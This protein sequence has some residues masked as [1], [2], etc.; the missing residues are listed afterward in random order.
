MKNLVKATAAV[1]AILLLA[2]CGKLDFSN[3]NSSTG[4]SK[5]GQYQT[6]GVASDGTYQGVIKN[7]RYQVSKSRGLMMQNNNQ[8]GN[9]FNV[10]SM[11][12]GLV[13]LSQKQF[14]T[15]KYDFEEG[16]LLS[17]SVTRKWL[18][19]QK[20]KF[21]K[22]GDTDNALGLNP[23][24]N[25]STDPN[26]RVPIYLQQL[27]EQD[28][29]VKS[30]NSMALGGISI[31]LGMNAID[32]YVKTQYGAQYQTNI[33]AAETLRMGKEM[34]AKVV[35]RLRQMK[36]VAANTPILVGI[37]RQ[38]GQDS[39]VGGTYQAYAVSK[40]GSTMGTW[41]GINEQ[42]EVLPVINNKKP[43][44]NTVATDFSN[45]SAQ[46]RSFFPT[47]AGVTAQAHYENGQLAGLKI[48][49]NTQFYGQTEI[50]SFTQYVSS[51]A[52]KLL[53]NSAKIEIDIESTQGM[54]AYAERDTGAKT[55]TTHVFDSY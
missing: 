42:N 47:L 51:A 11:E 13:S 34:A 31:G 55:F 15:D 20:G 46:V 29:M 4:T 26:K 21:S 2:G 10:R 40:S 8:N 7:G 14:S 12:S 54:Q 49:I 32:Y 6:T 27:L 28:Y 45:F 41:H 18:G 1:A 24:S 3:D 25:G 16:Q 53:P 36:G 37:Y 43:V 30:G 17:T 39:L 33:S 38:A 9:T 35:T 50:N 22:S 44:N 19:R 5:S 48:T 23:A 52:S